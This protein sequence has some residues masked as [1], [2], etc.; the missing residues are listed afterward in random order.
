MIAGGRILVALIYVLPQF[1]QEETAMAS[2]LVADCD[3]PVYERRLVARA[4]FLFA[5]QWY[6]R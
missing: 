4:V 3:A 2:A 6:L 1:H 5:V